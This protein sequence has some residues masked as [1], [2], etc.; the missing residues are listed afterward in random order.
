MSSIAAEGGD[1]RAITPLWQEAVVGLVAFGILCYVLLRFV[2]PRMEQTFEARI[3]AIEG[4][5]KRAESAQAEANQLLDQYKAELAEARADA[6]RIRQQARA[7]AESVRQDLLASVREESDRIL[8]TGK[9]QLAAERQRV[10]RELRAEVGTIAV[11]LASRIVGESLAE[12]A[13][14]N[15]TVERFVT[16]VENARP[17]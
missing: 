1:L 16:G 15:S 2:F 3:E 9:E 12:E 17:E 6:T 10:R 4:G 13:R 5:M 14:R 8:A 7:D 11:D